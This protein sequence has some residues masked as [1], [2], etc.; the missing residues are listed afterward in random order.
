MFWPILTVHR[1]RASDGVGA[2][3]AGCDHDREARL[4][5]AEG[6]VKYRSVTSVISSGSKTRRE[7][8]C[9]LI[10]SEELFLYLDI[11]RFIR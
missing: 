2:A 1:Q 7:D 11:G 4:P 5:L 3:A 10:D 9:Q 8:D 6:R